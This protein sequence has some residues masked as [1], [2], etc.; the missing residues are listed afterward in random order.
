MI[1]SVLIISGAIMVATTLASLLTLFQIRKSAGA[2]RS[3][4]AIFIADAG[5]ERAF[6]EKFSGGQC[7][8]GRHPATFKIGLYKFGNYNALEDYEYFIEFD[9]QDPGGDS[10]ASSTSAISAGRVGPRDG[11]IVTRAFKAYFELVES[12]GDQTGL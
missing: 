12:F 7:V 8:S 1:L 11:A 5:V 9:P 6:W 10:C 4:Q 3:A 2:E